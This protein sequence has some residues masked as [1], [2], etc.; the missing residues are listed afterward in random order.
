MVGHAVE[1]LTRPLVGRR[2]IVWIEDADDVGGTLD[3]ITSEGIRI[4][5]DSG[6]M[7]IPWGRIVAVVEMSDAGG[8]PGGQ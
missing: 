8:Q 5:G 6:T 2:V 3:T 4:V 7:A 1:T